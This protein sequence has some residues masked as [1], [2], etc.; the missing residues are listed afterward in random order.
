M[1]PRRETGVLHE[2]FRGGRHAGKAQGVGIQSVEVSPH[3]FGERRF[4]AALHPRHERL[5]AELIHL[6]EQGTRNASRLGGRYA[7][8]G[9]HD[10]EP[11]TDTHQRLRLGGRH[12][13]GRAG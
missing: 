1:L 6:V 3:Q 9:G 2:I 5:I 7:P 13:R 4:V 11:A 8:H 12:N 10:D